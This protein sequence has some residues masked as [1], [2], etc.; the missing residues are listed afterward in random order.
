[1]YM[2]GTLIVKPEKDKFWI[3]CNQLSTEYK[4]GVEKFI[5]FTIKNVEGSSV[6]RCP[7][8]DFGNL[9]FKTPTTVKDNLYMHGFDL[10]DDN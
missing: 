3:Q 7:C 8:L 4:E 9:S 10:K 1:M 5:N 2:S 6:V